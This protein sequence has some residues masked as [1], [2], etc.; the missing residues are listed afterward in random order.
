MYK[1]I[2]HGFQGYQ[3]TRTFDNYEEADKLFSLL[4]INLTVTC[5]VELM[6]DDEL[7]DRIV[8]I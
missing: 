2:Y 6:K 1:V 4:A 5:Y 8:N 7:I 3:F